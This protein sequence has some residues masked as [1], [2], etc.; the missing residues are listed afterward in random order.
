M[1]EPRQALECPVREMLKSV[2]LVLTL[3]LRIVDHCEKCL[4]ER[5]TAKT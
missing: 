2:D 3:L 4:E 1:N 5:R